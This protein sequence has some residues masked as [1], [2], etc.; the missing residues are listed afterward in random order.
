M[1]DQELTVLR[2]KARLTRAHRR[3][4]VSPVEIKPERQHLYMH[5]M[6]RQ[7]AA[8]RRS[9]ARARA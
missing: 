5:S 8:L 1:R 2:F 7:M 3:G 4:N 9:I 6:A